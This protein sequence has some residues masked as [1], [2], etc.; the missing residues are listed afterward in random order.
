MVCNGWNA[1]DADGYKDF[2]QVDRDLGESIFSFSNALF[3]IYS[4]KTTLKH[5]AGFVNRQIEQDCPGWNSDSAYF[6]PLFQC[7][8]LLRN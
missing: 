2:A 3:N 8:L 5:K 7:H 1:I 4:I 6:S